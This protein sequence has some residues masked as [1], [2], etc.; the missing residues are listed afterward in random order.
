MDALWNGRFEGGILNLKSKCKGAFGGEG[1]RK[2]RK[3]DGRRWY[4]CHV[5]LCY[6]NTPILV[7]LKRTCIDHL[8][9]QSVSSQTS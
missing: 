6:S 9:D 2:K 3:V 1:G 4:V 5:R 7:G 8:H